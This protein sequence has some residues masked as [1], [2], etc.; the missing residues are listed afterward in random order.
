MLFRIIQV[1]L[2]TKGSQKEVRVAKKVE[3][4]HQILKTS[5]RSK[6]G[7]KNCEERKSREEKKIKRKERT[8]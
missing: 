3:S 5:M 8:K 7:Q 4:L 2:R 1:K 6:H